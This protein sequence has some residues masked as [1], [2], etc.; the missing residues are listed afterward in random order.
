MRYLGPFGLGALVFGATDEASV[1]MVFH[2][3]HMPTLPISQ[4]VGGAD[5]LSLCGL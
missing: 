1:I 5:F 2:N 3:E 4:G